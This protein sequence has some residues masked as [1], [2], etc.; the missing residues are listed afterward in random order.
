MKVGSI[1]HGI[2]ITLWAIVGINVLGMTAAYLASRDNP[3]L[4]KTGASLAVVIP[5]H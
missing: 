1:E 4:S 2:Y 3:I 5:W